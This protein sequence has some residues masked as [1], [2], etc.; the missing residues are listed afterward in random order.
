MPTAS[1][2]KNPPQSNQISNHNKNNAGIGST[3]VHPNLSTNNQTN[4]FIACACN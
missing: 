1:T 3:H 2:L 4:N